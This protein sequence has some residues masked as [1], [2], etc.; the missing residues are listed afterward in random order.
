MGAANGASCVLMKVAER[1]EAALAP[2]PSNYWCWAGVG[3]SLP[4]HAK[5]AAAEVG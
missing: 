5:Y 2:A 4:C 1:V 3:G